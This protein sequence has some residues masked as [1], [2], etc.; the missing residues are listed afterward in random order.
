MQKPELPDLPSVV[1]EFLSD[2]CA[3]Y[4][5]P[6]YQKGMV[7]ALREDYA[8]RWIG[9][10]VAEQTNKPCTHEQ[11]AKEVISPLMATGSAAPAKPAKPI[12]PEPPA[13][14]PGPESGA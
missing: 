2:A 13:A 7:I 9:K 5:C 11:D 10:G 1:V 6:K 12:K 14:A 3:G 4:L 8:Q